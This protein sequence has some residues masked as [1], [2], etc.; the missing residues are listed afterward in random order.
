[1]KNNSLIKFLFFSILVSSLYAEEDIKATN[2]LDSIVLGSGCFWG[3][4]KGYE[5]LLG[6]EEAISGYS[7]GRGVRPVYREII[8]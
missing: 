3:A 1:M 5:S 2:H 7:D 4:E 6:V 8:N